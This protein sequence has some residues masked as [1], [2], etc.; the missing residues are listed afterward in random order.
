MAEKQEVDEM[1]YSEEYSEVYESLTIR[2]PAPILSPSLM[3]VGLTPETISLAWARPSTHRNPENVFSTR[4]VHRDLKG[5]NE[6]E[7]DRML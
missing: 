2:T 4:I 3:V 5:K 6:E 7:L 1:R